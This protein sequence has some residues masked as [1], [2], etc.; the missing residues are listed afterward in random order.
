MGTSQTQVNLLKNN[1]HRAEVFQNG[2]EA[3]QSRRSL[4]RCNKMHL[5]LT[6]KLTEMHNS[7]FHLFKFLQIKYETEA[8]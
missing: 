2:C 4:V 7:A 6:L 5:E 3:C 8:C 1:H